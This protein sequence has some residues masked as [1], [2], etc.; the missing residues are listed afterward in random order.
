MKIGRIVK[1]RLDPEGRLRRDGR[2]L[3]PRVDHARLESVAARAA[4][5]DTPI[6]T[7]RE[8]GAFRRVAPAAAVDPLGVRRRLKMSQAAFAQIF[9]V[10]LRTVQEWE[11]RRRRPAGAARTLLRI[12]DREPD[13]VRRA[14]GF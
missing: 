5:P 1:A 9:G 12:I 3:R 6:L 8:L 2:P 11:Q 4:D 14:I 13:A 7:A 10:S